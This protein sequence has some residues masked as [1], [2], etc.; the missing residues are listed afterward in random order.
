M[1]RQRSPSRVQLVSVGTEDV[2]GFRFTVFPTE[3]QELLTNREHD[4]L[5]LAG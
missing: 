3:L 4:R 2:D 1:L 5:L